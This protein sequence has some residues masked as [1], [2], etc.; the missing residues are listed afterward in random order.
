M[1]IDALMIELDE[2]IAKSRKNS[3]TITTKGTAILTLTEAN[4]LLI[5]VL[6]NC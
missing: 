3:T 4:L 6:R 5:L 2:R 1:T